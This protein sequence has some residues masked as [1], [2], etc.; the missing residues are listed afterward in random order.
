ML[1]GPHATP[2]VML[3]VTDPSDVDAMLPAL[4]GVEASDE[5]ADEVADLA[6]Q[7]HGA[8]GT[9]ARASRAR[10]PRE[11]STTQTL[12]Y[13]D[14]GAVGV[15]NRSD[16]FLSVRAV[17]GRLVIAQRGGRLRGECDRLSHAGPP[18]PAPRFVTT[19]P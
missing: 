9:S 5:C 17:R 6:V 14:S 10:G 18:V 4:G 12:V 1:C 2:L 8:G 16:T 11:R 19:C 13:F 7:R 3:V 15:N